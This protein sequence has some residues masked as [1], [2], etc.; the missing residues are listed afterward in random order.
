M[1][2]WPDEVQAGLATEVVGRRVVYRSE[3]SSTN[4]D[5]K[6]LADAGEPEGTVL[7]TD[8]QVAGRGRFDRRWV[9]PPGTSV[10]LSLLFRP[11]LP[12]ERV[13]Q[14]TML[15]SLAVRDVIQASGPAL[16]SPHA[17]GWLAQL[18]WPN[19]VVLNGRKVAGLL[20]EVS[21]AGD[22][23]D[24]VIVG[25]GLNVN[26]DP[27]QLPSGLLASATSLQAELGQR[28][29]RRGLVRGLLEGVDRR[30]AALRA[31][32]RFAGE[33]SDHLLTLGQP[34]RV[35]EGEAT[36]EGLAEAVDEGGALLVRHQDG[37]LDTVWAADV[38]LAAGE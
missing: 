11:S 12:Q 35:S 6:R 4:D 10:L 7:L 32:H 1:S 22:A 33:W 16:D 36:W 17:G 27:A 20:T 18:K 38:T 34:V 30:Y 5:L 19:D 28:V 13:G 23:L 31:G 24:Y 29:E 9:A 14:L 21:F 2:P 15:C 25:I 3:V 8:Y 26:L 37:S